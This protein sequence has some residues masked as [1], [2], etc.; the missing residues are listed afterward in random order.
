MSKTTIPQVRQKKSKTIEKIFVGG[1]P[2]DVDESEFQQYF[3]KFGTVKLVELPRHQKSGGLKGFAFI[4]FTDKSAIKATLSIPQHFILGKKVAVREGLN[5]TSASNQTKKLQACKIFV[6]GFN[7]NV[8]ENQIQAFFENFGQVNRI[9][10]SLHQRT[11]R[12]RGFCYVIMN[13][14]QVY[15]NLIRLGKL[16]FQDTTLSLKAAQSLKEITL[17]RNDPKVHQKQVFSSECSVSPN[18]AYGEMDQEQ[19]GRNS[20]YGLLKK[21]SLASKESMTS[22]NSLSPKT[23]GKKWKK[24][25]RQVQP[26]SDHPFINF[27]ET[28]DRSII[29]KIARVTPNT[30][31]TDQICF[32][33][34]LKPQVILF[35]NYSQGNYI[36]Y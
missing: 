30:C 31:M 23:S 32:R 22:K 28:D 13:D 7:K 6:Q 19:S 1:I 27:S 33:Y 8:S 2:R 14:Q 12:F 5:Y 20:K 21:N 18:Y 16:Q 11:G 34:S 26:K 15:R 29:Q 9:L 36:S 4:S 24:L 10:Y 3:S 17:E 35:D 25:A